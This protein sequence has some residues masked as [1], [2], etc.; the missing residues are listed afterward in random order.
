M[1]RRPH[2]EVPMS[3]LATWSSRVAMFSLAV[4]ALSIIIVRSNLLELEPALATFGAA[5]ALAALAMLLAFASFVAIWRQGLGGLGR[6]LTGLFVGL[7]L[8]AYPAYLGYRG[9]KLPPINDIST[10]TAN[11]P[12]FTALAAQRP[13]GHLAYPGA[14]VAAKQRAAY[15]DLAPLQEDATPQ[16]VYRAV[17]GVVIKRKWQLVDAHPPGG[18]R[19]SG[20][21]EL[22][23]R[24]PIMGFRDDISI[25]I[26]PDEDGSVIDV[27]SASRLGVHDFGANASRVRALLEDIDD[28]VG[29]LPAEPQA[30]P[31]KEKKPAKRPTTRRA[32]RR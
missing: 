30:E 1:A 6:A 15:P 7:L 27:R 10:D 26:N 21:I 18:A 19:R 32:P 5:L 20:T 8:L 31:E 24:T 14:A 9:W 23:A 3:R 22:T 16:R 29:D 28:A 13:P 4:T 17:L 2:F 12:A 11:P 25:R